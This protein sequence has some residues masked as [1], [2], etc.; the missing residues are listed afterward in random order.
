MTG[1]GEL[2]NRLLWP[3]MAMPSFSLLSHLLPTQVRG[4]KYVGTEPKIYP[5]LCHQEDS[6]SPG[7]A[8]Y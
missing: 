6:R 3:L 1:V 7:N 2:L 8:F 5:G 4:K